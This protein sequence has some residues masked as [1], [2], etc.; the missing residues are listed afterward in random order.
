MQF[1]H[2]NLCLRVPSC[3]VAR[4]PSFSSLVTASFCSVSLSLLLFSS[5]Q[6]CLVFLRF[7]IYVVSQFSR[8]VMDH[9]IPGVPVHHQLLDFT[10][11][12][13]RWV[14]DAIQPSHPPSSPAFNRS[15]HQGLFQWVNSSH[16]V[17]KALEFQLQHQSFQWTFRT[18]F[19]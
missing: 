7:H 17:A 9:S 12:H 4:A 6:E 16:Q 1:T 13:V 15:Q 10:Q 19:L 18:D 2:R 14:G 5:I 3:C 11:T 8:S